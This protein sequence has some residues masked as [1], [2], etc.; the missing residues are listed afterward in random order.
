MSS[1]RQ[2]NVTD[3]IER[4]SVLEEQKENYEG[5]ICMTVLTFETS[6]NDKVSDRIFLFTRKPKKRKQQRSN[7][8]RMYQNNSPS[9][10]C[11]PHQLLFEKGKTLLPPLVRIHSVQSE[12]I[13]NA[14]S[15]H[16]ERM[17]N[18]SQSLIPSSNLVTDF[19][20]VIDQEGK[21]FTWYV[22]L[23]LKA[24]LSNVYRFWDGV[25]AFSTGRYWAIDNYQL[26]PLHAREK[27]AVSHE[28][29]MMTHLSI[30]T[31]PENTEI[32]IGPALAQQGCGGGG[33]QIY[34]WNDSV[35]R[36]MDEQAQIVQLGR[37]N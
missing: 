18:L 19:L 3:L 14:L 22:Y 28:W 23:K 36:E 6:E 21:N 16:R 27:L 10:H 30:T 13:Q 1:S 7:S 26:N 34:I 31:I 25:K 2:K 24:P 5:N 12:Y 15:Q 29:N 9:L 4:R 37:S 17:Q 33:I 8:G 35:L 32:I 11:F 20:S